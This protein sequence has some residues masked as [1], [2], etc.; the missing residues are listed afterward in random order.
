MHHIRICDAND[1]DDTSEFLDDWSRFHRSAYFNLFIDIIS[2]P[3]SSISTCF[4]LTS[5]SGLADTGKEYF[6]C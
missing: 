5:S 2:S 1:D 3:Q 6:G 4:D